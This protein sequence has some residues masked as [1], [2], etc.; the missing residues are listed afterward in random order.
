MRSTSSN[1]VSSDNVAPSKA[2][3]LPPLIALEENATDDEQVAYIRAHHNAMIACRERGLKQQLIENAQRRF[4]RRR[5]VVEDKIERW[6][7]G[8]SNG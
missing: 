1:I 5:N 8:I 7:R 4:S 6:M 3:G 2:P